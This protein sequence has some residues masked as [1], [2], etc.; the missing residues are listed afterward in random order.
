MIDNRGGANGAVAHEI[1]A[2]AAADGYTLFLGYMSA[3]TM[4]PVLY[5]KLTYDP[6]KDFAVISLI[7]RTT[8]TLVAA[9]SFPANSIKELMSSSRPGSARSRRRDK[10]DPVPHTRSAVCLG[11][12]PGM[13][14]KYLISNNYFSSAASPSGSRSASNK[15]ANSSLASRALCISLVSSV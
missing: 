5:S 12:I 1:V 15:V 7:G 6:V 14:F 8:L 3:L 9:P 2:R 10:P 13:R 11:L 4:N